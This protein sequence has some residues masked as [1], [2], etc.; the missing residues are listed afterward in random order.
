MKKPYTNI[1]L[2]LPALIIYAAQTYHLNLIQD[3]AYITYR[4]VANFLNGNGLVFNI[5][6]HIE[7][8]TN[9]AWAVYLIFWGRLGVD[10]IL[11]SR[12]TGFAFGGGVVVLTYL[13]SQLVLSD[14]NKM[15]ALLPTYLVAINMSLAYWSPAGLETAAFA[16]FAML[17]VYF[18][19]K[20]DWLLIVSLAIAVGIRPE[21]AV[22]TGILIASEAIVNRKLPW[23]S[24]RCAVVAFVI[25][26]PYVFF[27]IFY[28]GGI[29]PNPFYA[30]TG[31]NLAHLL[32]GLEYAGEFFQHYGFYGAG[33][34]LTLFFYKKLTKVERFIWL[35]TV[36]YILYI[37]LVG[38]D[39]LKVHRFFIPVFGLAAL[40][41]A[42]SLRLLTEKMAVKTR[43]LALFFVAVPLLALTYYMPKKTVATFQFNERMFLKKM[44]TL[45]QEMLASDSTN[46]SVAVPTIGIFGYELLGHKIIDMLGLTDSTIAR[47]S[48]E[49]IEGMETTW[50][51]AK[52]NSKYLIE[53]AP[54]Y[55]MFSTGRKPSA[56]AERALLL[57][58]QFQ[59]SYRAIGWFYRAFETQTGGVI[60]SVFKRVHDITGE[61][62]PT[63]PVEYVEYYKLGLDNYSRRDFTKALGFFNS[64]I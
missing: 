6:E 26:L 45:A 33:F 20:K 46:F 57:Y 62:K 54:D 13:I 51:E 10:I 58:P 39:V 49:P 64:V 4:Y 34:I 16:F 38:G 31:I 59:N 60:N 9:F 18:Y 48:E 21:G 2:L 17:S 22:V 61:I 53:S 56:P 24:I 19:L 37:V 27:K 12:L 44:R 40:L 1:L 28:Y 52:H 15:Y 42:V 25:S 47:H 29:L 55:I 32:N 30:K 36:F 11:V 63:Y 43:Y 23:F 50:K 14:K 7:G 3:D 41:V 35:F 8:I 5:G